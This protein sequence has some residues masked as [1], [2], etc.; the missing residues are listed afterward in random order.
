LAAIGSFRPLAPDES[1]ALRPQR[2]AVVSASP[3]ESAA[4]LATKSDSGDQALDRFLMLN[5]LDRPKVKAGEL[6]KI[7]TTD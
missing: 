5:G 2:I 3:E 4:S 1:N 6:Y 7:I